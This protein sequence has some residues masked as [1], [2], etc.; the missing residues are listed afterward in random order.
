[1]AAKILTD[2]Q[3]KNICESYNNGMTSVALCKQYNIS[4]STILKWLKRNNVKIRE[5]RDSF[6]ALV[7][8]DYFKII[9]D[10]NKAYWLGYLAADGC[11]AKSAGT[12]RSLRFYL[13]PKDMIVIN[14]FA[15][16]IK[17]NGHVRTPETSRGQYGICFNN[18]KFCDNLITLGYLDWKNGNP[19]MLSNVPDDL[20]H[21]FIRGFFDGDGCISGRKRKSGSYSSYINFAAHKND[22]PILEAVENIISKNTTLSAL[23]V[24]F[25]NSTNSCYIAWSG[26]NQV[27]KFGEWIYKDAKRFLERK[28]FRFQLIDNS[29]IKN[30]RDINNW[31][32][33]LKP[34][35]LKN[36]IDID[37][38]IDSFT[39]LIVSSGWLPLKY[40]DDD[41][42]SDLRKLKEYDIN[43]RINN[44][45]IK[46]GRNYGNKLIINFQ[47]DIWETSIGGRK[48]ISM[49][50][51]SETIVKK[52]VKALLTT[53]DS[54]T[55]D[56][57]IREL[58]FAG[59][60]RASIL[61]TPTTIAAIKKFNLAGKWFD[62]CA[63]W[64]NRMLAAYVLKYDY[65]ATD[66]AR[67]F[68]G[69]LKI[70]DY[71]KSNAI[72]H[73]KMFQEVEFDGDFIF[74]SPPF[75]DKEDYKLGP[76][77]ETFEEWYKSFLVNLINKRGNKRIV[78]HIDNT[79]CNRLEIDYKLNKVVY[80]TGT[81]H[82]APKEWFV[83]IL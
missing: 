63:G 57:F 83:E 53:G 81:Q 80:D 75:Y 17:Y 14:Q 25:S 55:A 70:K 30:W 6:S 42:K 74:T 79:I 41:I 32:C 24:K 82:K 45:V 54:I 40:S 65:E 56:R 50:K 29:F 52:A 26:N 5:S 46:N 37:K 16:D 69:L 10:Q 64:G 7:D 62:P 49:I 20:K 39:K 78:L 77:T 13:A 48:T 2:K 19:I 12:R 51:E 1:M 73:N 8:C 22:K 31:Q 9:D 23:G 66:P 15:N 61:S 38:M 43:G 27:K 47:P 21:H 33:D 58:Q 3:I 34:D 35:D 72:L 68:S 11:I 36:N 71:L 59:L 28:K 4:D 44:G 67:H 76:I 60:S 18:K